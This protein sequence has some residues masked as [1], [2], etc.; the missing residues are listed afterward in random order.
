MSEPRQDNTLTLE[1]YTRQAIEFFVNMEEAEYAALLG[2][3]ENL[4]KWIKG[5][6]TLRKNMQHG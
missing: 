4:H 2:R 5:A 1:E 6:E 3:I